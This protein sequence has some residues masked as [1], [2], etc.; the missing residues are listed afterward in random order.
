[1]DE[2]GRCLSWHK[3]LVVYA[4]KGSKR[5][6]LVVKEHAESEKIVAWGSTTGSI[7]TMILQ[8][9]KRVK[10]EWVDNLPVCSAYQMVPKGNMTVHIFVKWI[11]DFSKF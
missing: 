3:H 9:D 6:I 1:M 2:K 11:N 4:E 10:P 8:K 7:T 5:E